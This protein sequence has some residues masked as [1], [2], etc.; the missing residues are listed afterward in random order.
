M[1]RGYVKGNGYHPQYSFNSDHGAEQL[2]SSWNIVKIN[3]EF[4][5]IDTQWGSRIV[6]SREVDMDYN[7]EEFY[8]CPS[9]ADFIAT[10]FPFEESDQLLSTP[11]SFADYGASIK[12]WPL[13][14]KMQMTIVSHADGFIRN[15]EG[16]V[17]VVIE[18]PAHSRMNGSV[19]FQLYQ[20]NSNSTGHIGAKDLNDEPLN[21]FVFHHQEGLYDVFD[22]TPPE[23]GSFI[24]QIFGS[25]KERDI[26]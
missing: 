20:K 11:I 4:K 12:L 6:S 9:P 14:H 1:A 23:N 2:T 16:K 18:T 13:F 10:H 26:S 15:D 7:Y 5:I 8:F 19:T 25:H 24:F 3:D 22:I 17:V 21:S